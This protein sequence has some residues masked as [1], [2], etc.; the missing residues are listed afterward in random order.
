M[1]GHHYHDSEGTKT[2][3]DVI[4]VIL[5]QDYDSTQEE[6][7]YLNNLA[8]II[9]KEPIP[10]EIFTPLPISRHIPRSILEKPAVIYSWAKT[11]INSN[12]SFH[13]TRT[14]VVNIVDCDKTLYPNANQNEHLCAIGKNDESPCNVRFKRK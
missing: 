8:I 11:N 2:I 6:S 5:P 1:I 14:S 7:Y 9:L 12:W 4:D 13:E 10:L 3:L